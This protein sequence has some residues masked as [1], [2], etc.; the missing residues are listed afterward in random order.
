MTNTA[1]FTYEDLLRIAGDAAAHL[2]KDLVVRGI[3]TD[4]RTLQPGNAFIALRGEQFDGHDHIP[5]AIERGASLVV[6]R[7]TSDVHF[8]PTAANSEQQVSSDKGRRTLDAGHELTSYSLLAADGLK[9]LGSFAWYHR[10]RFHIPVV[11]VAG[12]AGKTS[13]KDLTAHVL[14]QR[15]NVLKTQANFNNQIGTPLTLLQLTEEHEAAV[16]EIGT[17][18][19]GEIE[20]LSAMVQPT[21]GVITSIGKEHLEK[22]I[23]LDGVERE[24][25][26][27]FD[28]L[29]DHGGLAFVNMDDDRLRLYGHGGKLGGRV[30]TYGIDHLA[31]IHPT[32]SFDSELHPAVHL[33]KDQLTLR[34]QMQTTGVAS[35]MNAACAT[36]IAW[37]LNL[38]AVE[39][40]RGLESYA[41]TVGH[42]Y[43][44]M[45]VQR[46]GE[47]VILNDTYN[48]NPDSMRMSLRTLRLY[49]TDR[50]LAVLGDMRELGDGAHEEH[51]A[52]LTEAAEIADLV[53]VYGPEFARAAELIERSNVIVCDTHS[54]C[55]R[56]IVE[57]THSG[58]AVLVKGSRGLQMEQVIHLL[59]GSDCAG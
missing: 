50:R 4:T 12:S 57:N 20:I 44:R 55:V 2:P 45:V 51:L 32:I 54:A 26:A 15:F 36:A 9:L 41:P 33:V 58:S 39:I 19:P 37:S 31:D 34:A 27:L 6:H 48:A 42:G 18:E 1:T 22:L 52:I 47:M 38:D 23:D 49:P 16:I 35:A 46:I 56:E 43:A 30:I 10:R 21:H 24:E 11:A 25:T 29:H 14:S 53:I 7:P 40:K 17:N 8:S 28:F 59:P 5:M 13:T 3:S